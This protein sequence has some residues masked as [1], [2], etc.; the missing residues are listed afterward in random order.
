MKIMLCNI[1]W[2]TKYEGSFLKGS[3]EFIKK[4]KGD[5]SERWNFKKFPNGKVYGYIRGMG[6]KKHSPPQ[7]SVNLQSR[8]TILFYAKDPNDQVL[9]FVGFYRNA[10]IFSQW[11]EHPI[12]KVIR[13]E[14]EKHVYCATTS[15]RQAILFPEDKRPV[16][17]K[18]FGQAGF[19]YLTNPKTR[20]ISRGNKS[21]YKQVLSYLKGRLPQPVD[22]KKGRRRTSPTTI[23]QEYREAV[24]KASMSFVTRQLRREGFSVK[25][26]SREK[27]GFDLQGERGA[28]IVY[29]EVKGTAGTEP[30]FI[31]TRNEIE[32]MGKDPSAIIAIVTTALAQP[33]LYVLKGL[34]IQKAYK[35]RPLQLEAIPRSNSS[36][37][38]TGRKKMF[39]LP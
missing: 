7:L 39:N 37:I 30:R 29:V 28:D 12:N 3:H 34:N 14:T 21:L 15:A 4:H 25:D 36:H 9:K 10:T 13:G 27:I 17:G 5:G 20:K 8:W 32:F 26:I 31:I 38:I 23:D 2:S 1:G 16:V 6:G 22:D 35:L 33:M 18:G 19:V 24:E 11:G